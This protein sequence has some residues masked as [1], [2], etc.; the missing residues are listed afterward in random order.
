MS[1]LGYYGGIITPNGGGGNTVYPEGTT[2]SI[3]KGLL[4]AGTDISGLTLLE[5]E[6]LAWSGF[7]APTFTSFSIS[8]AAIVEVGE[9]IS[10]NRTFSWA[11]SDIGNIS[12]NT[13]DIRDVT[14]ATLIAEDISKVSPA[15]VAI[16]TITKNSP[17]THQ[18][19]ALAQDLEANTIQSAI[20]SIT[21]RFKRF[22]GFVSFTNP[23]GNDAA[24]QALANDFTDSPVVSPT[25]INNPGGSNYPAIFI[26]ESE[27]PGSGAYNTR[28]QVWEG[29]LNKTT[30]YVYTQFNFTN[31]Q[32]ISESYVAIIQ[33]VPTASA[34]LTIETRL[35]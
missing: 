16:G 17:G 18:W 33:N 29:G 32:G 22:Y 28:L 11:F 26:R 9:T 19:R 35:P 13:L 34:Q 1:G 5:V 21:W 10:G 3:D 12:D 23:V 27:I 6:I 2:L 14:N 24:I 25:L 8:G 15:S 20:D 31:A 30:A 7:N 4:P